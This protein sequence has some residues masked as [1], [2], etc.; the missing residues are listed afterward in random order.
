MIEEDDICPFCN[1]GKM[2]VPHMNFNVNANSDTKIELECNMCRYRIVRVSP[3]VENVHV[4]DNVTAE[5]T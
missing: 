3:A 4:D 1:A 2:K 5:R